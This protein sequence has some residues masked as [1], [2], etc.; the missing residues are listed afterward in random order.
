VP[1]PARHARRSAGERRR[2]A[3]RCRC[4]RARSRRRHSEGRCER[5][6]P[7][8]VRLERLVTGWRRRSRLGCDSGRSLRD[9]ISSRCWSRRT[10]TR[11]GRER[12]ERD[13][14]RRRRG[15]DMP[16][17]GHAGQDVGA[18]RFF[19]RPAESLGRTP[20]R[21]GDERER[22]PVGSDRDRCRRA[23]HAGRRTA[24]GVPQEYVAVAGDVGSLPLNLET[25]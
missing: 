16:A 4:G 17:R 11:Q 6:D 7:G 1:T 18:Q 2:H 20:D 8:F 5:L 13:R 19:S 3:P 23:A 9:H 12:F 15:R 14:G 10:G 22:T 24:L 21:R 25:V